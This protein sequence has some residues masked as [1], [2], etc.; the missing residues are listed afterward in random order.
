M[1][2]NY[3]RC[4][5]PVGRDRSPPYSQKIFEAFASNPRKT[6]KRSP[7]MGVDSRS[8]FESLI[9]RVRIKML[10][11]TIELKFDGYYREE[12][13]PPSGHDCKGIYVV[14][15]GKHT[16]EG[17]CELYK[18]LY[19]GKSGDVAKRPRSSHE[20][21]EDWRKHLD[22]KKGEILYFSFADTDDE[23]LA[24][25][26]LIYKI[27]PVCNDLGKDAFHKE[28]TTIKT[29]GD[30]YLLGELFTVHETD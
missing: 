23:E 7:E 11:N 5:K 28:N 20:K 3:N 19:I 2:Y 9:E 6:G 15:V 18:L 12:Q 17:G 14:Y 30:N 1:C 21:Y 10:E 24:E 22:S 26:A 13:L 25:A 16:S 4:E 29:S 27:K 8:D